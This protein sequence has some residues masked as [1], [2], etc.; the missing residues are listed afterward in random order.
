MSEWSRCNLMN[1]WSVVAREKETNKR[2]E[3]DRTVWRSLSPFWDKVTE[4]TPQ[5]PDG[6][7]QTDSTYL[8][9]QNRPT[10]MIQ[11]RERQRT[12]KLY[13]KEREQYIISSHV[14]I[15]SSLGHRSRCSQAITVN[16]RPSHLDLQKYHIR[17][18]GSRPI[19]DVNPPDC[20]IWE[21]NY[22]NKKEQI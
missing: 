1:E 18:H 14:R 10:D 3:K 13:I 8:F 11:K 2:E 4:W 19:I 12:K 7:R 9:P 5:F 20:P 6:E 15:S 16:S 22:I 17:Y 21:R